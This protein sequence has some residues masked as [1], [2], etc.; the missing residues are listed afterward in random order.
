MKRI[1]VM[2]GRSGASL[3][4]G[5][6]TSTNFRSVTG[7]TNSSSGDEN[8][9]YGAIILPT[10]LGNTVGWFGLGVYTNFG[11]ARN[12]G[13]YLRLSGRQAEWDPVV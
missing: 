1:Q 9:D 8:Y 13:K 10:Q 7:W 4:Y 12:G 3:P 2:A 11:L 5:T 6:V